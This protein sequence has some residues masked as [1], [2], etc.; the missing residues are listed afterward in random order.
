MILRN[1][2][3]LLYLFIG[4]LQSI[5]YLLIWRP[6]VVFVK[7]GFVGLPVGIAAGLLRRPLVTHDSDAI[8]GLTNKLL[9][10]F[11]TIHA[12][13]MPIE[14]YRYPKNKMQYTGIPIRQEFIDLS[15]KQN[16]TIFGFNDESKPL[17]LIVGGSLGA[18]RLNNAVLAGLSDLVALNI[19][20]FWITGSG[21][22]K[23]I[24]QKLGQRYT[25]RIIIKPY[26]DE[27]AEL[28][29]GSSIVI[30]RAGATSLAE[31]AILS[32]PTIIVPNPYLTGGHQIKNA[33]IYSEANAA[34]V[35]NEAEL[36]DPNIL[37]ESINNLLKND[38]LKSELSKNI[39]KFAIKNGA[40]N[41]V[42]VIT[43]IAG[44]K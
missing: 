16:N 36:S 12:V 17:V 35:I 40:D 2:R 41:I 25:N 13:G 38:K 11:V 6:D 44:A 29:A 18:V 10:K 43:K 39:N 9:S 26:S 7:G 30:S 15:V 32:K 21:Q 33:N 14:N 37:V 3:D 31:L 22:Y 28:M 24:Q 19:N 27:T 1:F 8:P 34:I 23:D 4:T 20:I 42:T 5:F